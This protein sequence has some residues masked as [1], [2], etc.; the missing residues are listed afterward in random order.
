MANFCH[1]CAQAVTPEMRACPNCGTT[2]VDLAAGRVAPPPPPPPFHE[3]LAATWRGFRDG[4]TR[5]LRPSPYE[6]APLGPRLGALLIDIVVGFGAF[7]PGAALVAM[8]T[9]AE[10]E[11][12]MVAGGLTLLLGFL[13]ALYYGFTKDGATGQSIGKRRMGLMVVHL[14]TARPCTR[15]QSAVRAL[16]MLLSGLVPGIGWLIEPVAVLV[17]R[18]GRRIGDHAADTHVIAVADYA[19]SHSTNHATSADHLAA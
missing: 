3:E 2:L 4:A 11:G 14:P 7:V 12:M 15:G 13:W 1:Q 16:V 8:G 5:M 10:D 18:D 19:T 9:A 6:R 17:V